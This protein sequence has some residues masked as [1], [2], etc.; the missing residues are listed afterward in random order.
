M[1]LLGSVISALFEAVLLIG[2]KR[3]TKYLSTREVVK[4]TYQGRR[5]KRSKKHVVVVTVGPPNYAERLFIKKANRVGEPFP[6][7]RIQ[8]KFDK[9][10]VKG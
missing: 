3:A 5:D 8:L 10:R 4:A 1:K 7:K 6:V 2:A 9:K